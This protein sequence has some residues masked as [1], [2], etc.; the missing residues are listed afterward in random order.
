MCHKGAPHLNMSIFQDNKQI[1]VRI[2]AALIDWKIGRLKGVHSFMV[3][4]STFMS[5]ERHY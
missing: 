2:D 5:A 3:T 1:T 4:L